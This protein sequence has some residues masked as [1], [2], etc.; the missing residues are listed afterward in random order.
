MLPGASAT[1]PRWPVGEWP[2]GQVSV[3][4]AG[5]RW[6]DGSLRPCVEDLVGAGDNVAYCLALDASTVVAVLVDG[7]FTRA[8]CARVGDAGGP[9]PLLR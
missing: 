1:P 2:A 3:V 4:A 5:K 7:A 9:R 6:S 8:G